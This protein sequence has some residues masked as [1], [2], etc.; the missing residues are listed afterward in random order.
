[1]AIAPN[2]YVNRAPM[3]VNGTLIDVDRT[4]MNASGRKWPK[5]GDGRTKKTNV[6]TLRA[7][8]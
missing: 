3:N 4:L 5:K 8:L 7:P 6:P 2:G 1:M